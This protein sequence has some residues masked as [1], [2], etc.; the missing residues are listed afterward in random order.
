MEVI[1]RRTK[2]SKPVPVIRVYF[3]TPNLS[4]S[5]EVATFTE[6]KYFDACY[7]QLEKVAKQEGYLLTENLS[8][9]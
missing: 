6:E 3:E 7:R 8:Q 2:M 4:S 9:S 1:M 5:Y